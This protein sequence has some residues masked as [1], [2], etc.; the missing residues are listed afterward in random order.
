LFRIRD[1]LTAEQWDT[2][3]Y[4]RLYKSFGLLP[5]DLSDV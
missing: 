1:G 5:D 4:V 3:D 2:V